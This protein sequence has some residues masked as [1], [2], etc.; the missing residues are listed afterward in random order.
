MFT[1]R[2]RRRSSPPIRIPRN[3]GSSPPVTCSGDFLFFP[4]VFSAIDGVCL[5]PVHLPFHADLTIHV[6]HAPVGLSL[7]AHVREPRSLSSHFLFFQDGGIRICELTIN[8]N[9]ASTQHSEVSYSRYELDGVEQTEKYPPSFRVTLETSLSKSGSSNERD[10]LH[11]QL[12]QSLKR[13]Q[14]LFKDETELRQTIEE[15]GKCHSLSLS[16]RSFNLL[17]R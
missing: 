15:Y 14:C 8:A 10:F 5:I 4:S 16:L 3:F 11:K 9:F 13:P 2:S 17:L 6:S 1:I 7:Q 12:D